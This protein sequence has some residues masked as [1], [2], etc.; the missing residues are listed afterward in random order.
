MEGTANVV[1]IALSQKIEKLAHVSS[2]AALNRYEDNDEVTEENY[3]K[4]NPKNSNYAISKYFQNKKYG[5]ESKKD[6]MR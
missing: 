6:L 5:A 1:N 3:W 4:P 2:I